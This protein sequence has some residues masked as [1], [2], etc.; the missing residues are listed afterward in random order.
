M[1]DQLTSSAEALR[2]FFTEDI[3]LIK[4]TETIIPAAPPVS[5]IKQ[6][7]LFKYL[8]KNQKNILILVNDNQH[9]VSS[10]RGRELLRN[11]VKAMEL[12]A[13]D[14]ALVNYAAYENS[15]LKE[16]TDFF[17]SK[18]VLVFGV[19]SLAL[20]LPEHPQHVLLV[21]DNMQMIFSL[22]LDA[23]AADQNGKKVLWGSLK[24]INNS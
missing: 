15:G 16:L 1:G 10:E 17:S 18:L 14:F 23:L 9:E 7:T 20:G 3:Y 12:T 21:K 2:L 5:E 8:G 24:Q 6:D 19:Q 4:G 11:I 22:N 13:N